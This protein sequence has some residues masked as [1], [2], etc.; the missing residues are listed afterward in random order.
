MIELPVLSLSA[1]LLN[2]ADKYWV[3]ETG[4]Q[5]WEDTNNWSDTPDGVEGASLPS[6]GDTVHFLFDAAVELDLTIQTAVKC[7]F[8]IAATAFINLILDTTNAELSLISDISGLKNLQTGFYSKLRT[9]N[10]D[11]TLNNSFI[12]LA[13]SECYLGTSTVNIGDGT[14]YRAYYDIA[15]TV[16]MDADEATFNFYLCTSEEAN[17]I[18]LRAKEYGAVNIYT[19]GE[20]CT[21]YATTCTIGSFSIQG[22]G[23]VNFSYDVSTPAITT[24][25]FSP[26]GDTAGGLIIQHGTG[27]TITQASG[28]VDAINCDIRKSIAT[29]G[30]IFNAFT[31]IGNVDGGGNT[32]WTFKMNNELPLLSLST[33][34]FTWKTRDI[35]A[36]L[37]VPIFSIDTFI[38]QN[39]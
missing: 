29:G 39:V 17:F 5:V 1:S 35:D 4:E 26:A 7:H 30:A 36:T 31:S 6:P 15:D 18:E 3:G 8:D 21:L 32:G 28:T 34:I 11:I 24:G 13:L 9:N 37:T 19:L 2:S 12:C 10:F 20:S 38:D 33:N 14:N 25:S 27:W 23:A 22:D 16:V